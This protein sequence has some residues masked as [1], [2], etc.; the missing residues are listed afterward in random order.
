MVNTG[1]EPFALWRGE[2]PGTVHAA[3]SASSHVVVEDLQLPAI[4]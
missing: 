3:F 4:D 1:T 2:K